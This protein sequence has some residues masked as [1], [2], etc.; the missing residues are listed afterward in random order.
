MNNIELHGRAIISGYRNG[1]KF[2]PSAWSEMLSD[3]AA[4]FDARHHLI[5]ADYLRPA[6]SDKYGHYVEVDFD[7][8]RKHRPDVYKQVVE[9][10]ASNRLELYTPDGERIHYEPQAE[11]AQVEAA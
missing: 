2:R 9:F 1:A 4:E 3:M 11:S 5:Y 6:F 7:A 10:I 8:L